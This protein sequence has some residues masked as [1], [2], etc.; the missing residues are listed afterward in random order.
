VWLLA[1]FQIVKIPPPVFDKL[2]RFGYRGRAGF[3]CGAQHLASN[4]EDTQKPPPYFWASSTLYPWLMLQRAQHE[5]V[6]RRRGSRRSSEL[7]K[8]CWNDVL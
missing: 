7:S 4:F 5:R 1:V 2:S 3:I 8:S 6:N